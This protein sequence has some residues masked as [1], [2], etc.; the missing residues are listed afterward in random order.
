MTITIFH[1]AIDGTDLAKRTFTNLT[2]ARRFAQK[3]IGRFPCIEDTY[4]V[5]LDTTGERIEARGC[6]V[7]DLFPAGARL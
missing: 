7:A 5:D 4:A 1:S 3:A 2:A 6:K